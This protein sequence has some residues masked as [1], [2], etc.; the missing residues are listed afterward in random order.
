MRAAK[1]KGLAAP[2]LKPREMFKVSDA[3]S[4]PPKVE[5]G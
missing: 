3:D 2:R 5:L 1:G 4:Q